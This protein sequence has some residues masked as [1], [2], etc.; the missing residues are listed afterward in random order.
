[1]INPQACVAQILLN[2]PS[3]LAQPLF[4]LMIWMA[5]QPNLKDNA[6]YLAA[7]DI[8]RQILTYDQNGCDLPCASSTASN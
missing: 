3:E 2:A 8:P 6:E 7:L 4:D 1:M 5:D